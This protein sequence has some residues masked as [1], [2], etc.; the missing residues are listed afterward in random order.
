MSASTLDLVADQG[1]LFPLRLGYSDDQGLLI[2]L[3][4]DYTVQFVLRESIDAQTDI[5]LLTQADGEIT[6]SDGLDGFNIDI[7][8]GKTKTAAWPV[9]RSGKYEVRLWPTATPE[10][11]EILLKGNMEI[12]KGLL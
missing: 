3:S 11:V 2:D 7:V 10:E 5:E 6:L 1:G 12:R 8:I 4:T 9:L